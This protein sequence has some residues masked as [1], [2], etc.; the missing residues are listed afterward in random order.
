MC[1]TNSKPARAKLHHHAAKLIFHSL[2]PLA[3]MGWA[4][5]PENP[6]AVDRQVEAARGGE[7]MSL[8]LGG[9]E[10]NCAR[11]AHVGSPA[12]RRDSGAP[13]RD[14]S[15][16]LSPRGLRILMVSHIK[17]HEGDGVPDWSRSSRGRGLT[18]EG[19]VRVPNLFLY[20]VASLT[21]WRNGPW[22]LTWATG[23]L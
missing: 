1:K 21:R 18:S 23:A 4:R 9:A 3:G 12:S 17:G 7:G 10:F 20:S 6:H 15:G 5:R 16:C 11:D 19:R 2:C 22:T 8:A 13:F 14:Q